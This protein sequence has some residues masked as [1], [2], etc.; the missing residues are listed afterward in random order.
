MY[1]SLE[2]R[3]DKENNMKKSIAT[4]TL[5]V[6][7]GS[8]AISK[9]FKGETSSSYFN[10]ILSNCVYM[11]GRGAGVSSAVIVFGIKRFRM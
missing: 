4:A 2:S 10:S 11:E 7:F 1:V 6:G 3:R 5:S 9:N 8:L